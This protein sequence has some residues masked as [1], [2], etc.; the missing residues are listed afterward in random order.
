MAHDVSGACE[1]GRNGSVFIRLEA[2]EWEGTAG[3]SAS[4][5]S[6]PPSLYSSSVRSCDL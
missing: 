1:S 6:P 3:V 2:W 4:S 5:L